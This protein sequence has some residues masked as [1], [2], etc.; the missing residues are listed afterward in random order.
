[1]TNRLSPERRGPELQRFVAGLLDEAGYEHVWPPTLFFAMRD[2]GQP[3]Y[4]AECFVGRDI[5]SK[6]RKVDFILYHPRKWPHSLVIQ[7]KWQASGGSVDEKYPFEVLNIQQSGY[8]S[9][10][11]LDGGGYSKSAEQ[12]LKGQSG[13]NLLRHVF[14]M[15]EFQRFVSRG[16]I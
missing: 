5:Y 15:G 14:N 6:N 11:V 13:K 16:E 4:A 7:C 3:I 9:I 12:W 2:L 1:M 10:I 8:P